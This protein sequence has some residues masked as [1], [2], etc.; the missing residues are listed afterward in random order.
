MA[1]AD[2]ETDI[3]SHCKVCNTPTTKT[4]ILKHMSFKKTLIGNVLRT[5]KDHNSEEYEMVKDA[6]AELRKTK[7]RQQKR[8]YNEANKETIR[9]NQAKRD[10]TNRQSQDHMEKKRLRQS[11]YNQNHPN[12]CPDK[13]GIVNKKMF[14]ILKK[15]C[16]F[17]S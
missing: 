16:V 6:I 8:V 14:T 13:D 15:H 2:P 5:C 9:Q 7:Q 4:T 12:R 3:F 10:A 1:E 11:E 17:Y